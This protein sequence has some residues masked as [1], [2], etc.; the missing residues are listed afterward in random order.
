MIQGSNPHQDLKRV[1]FCIFNVTYLLLFLFLPFLLGFNLFSFFS[2][3]FMLLLYFSLFLLLFA[4][5]HFNLRIE[6]RFSCLRADKQIRLFE[7]D[8]IGKV[9]LDEC[10]LFELVRCSLAS[11]NLLKDCNRDR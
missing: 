9:V 6:L 2:R 7:N 8:S 10:V 5:L 11:S 3:A 1:L 4:L